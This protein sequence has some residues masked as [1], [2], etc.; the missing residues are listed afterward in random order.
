MEE[1]E[2]ADDDASTWTASVCTAHYCTVHI[3]LHFHTRKRWGLF[4]LAVCVHVEVGSVLHTYTH[5]HSAYC[6]WSSSSVCIVHV[7]W[8]R[9]AGIT[10]ADGTCK[11]KQTPSSPPM[12]LS[13]GLFE[14]LERMLVE[15]DLIRLFFCFLPTSLVYL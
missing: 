5:T 14:L 6:T 1:G 11:D 3:P 9:A 13:I 4:V 7:E 2:G 15:G 12:T 10:T 8:G